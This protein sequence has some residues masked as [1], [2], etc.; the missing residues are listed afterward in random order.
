LGFRGF[1]FE[2]FRTLHG[3]A[4]A[5][6]GTDIDELLFVKYGV[7]CTVDIGRLED[8]HSMLDVGFL[9]GIYDYFLLIRRL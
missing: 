8:K 4:N 5:Y 1:G 7:R 9:C 3:K 2:R 6:L